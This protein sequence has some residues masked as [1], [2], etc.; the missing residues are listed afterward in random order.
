MEELGMEAVWKITVEDFPA[1]IIIDDKGNDFFKNFSMDTV[2]INDNVVSIINEFPELFAMIDSS[3]NS[4]IE[5]EEIVAALG[6]NMKDAEELI[7]KYD[8]A[9]IGALDID[10]FLVAYSQDQT[11]KARVEEMYSNKNKS[12]VDEYDD[13]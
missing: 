4:R 7:A 9:K 1:F 11:L 13:D 6:Y 5:A 8:T 12:L 2:E 10:Q 3:K